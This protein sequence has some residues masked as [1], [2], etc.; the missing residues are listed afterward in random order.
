MCGGQL[1][2]AGFVEAEGSHGA[3]GVYHL[4]TMAAEVL[5]SSSDRGVIPAPSSTLR[6]THERNEEQKRH[7]SGCCGFDRFAGLGLG[8]PSM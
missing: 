1:S 6:K 5:G 2:Q 8:T 3:A 7:A 4:C